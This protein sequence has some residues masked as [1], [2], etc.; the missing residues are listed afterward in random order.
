MTPATKGVSMSQKVREEMLPRLRQRYAGRE[1]RSRKTA[2]CGACCLAG[3]PKPQINAFE[4][5]L[6]EKDWQ[7][8]SSEV[9]VKL[10]PNDNDVRVLARSQG[11]V[12]KEHAMHRRALK[13]CVRDLIK[14]KRAVAREL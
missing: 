1:G 14:F 4:Q 8:A 13:A 5:H 9:E 7:K 12:Q 11:R 6:T 3:T 2:R 10:C